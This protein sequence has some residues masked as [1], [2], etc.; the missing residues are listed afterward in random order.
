MHI[1]LSGRRN[2]TV[3]SAAGLTGGAFELVLVCLQCVDGW[4]FGADVG[5]K[6]NWWCVGR[7]GLCCV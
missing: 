5:G 4:A 6:I 2:R 3:T 7:Y 1:S